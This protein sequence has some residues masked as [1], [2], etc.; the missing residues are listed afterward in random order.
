[1]ADELTGRI[2]I[3]IRVVPIICAIIG[4]S[5]F[6]FGFF[7]LFISVRTL[8]ERCDESANNHWGHQSSEDCELAGGFF[9][10]SFPILLIGII[11]LIVAYIMWNSNNWRTLI[12][13][14]V[15]LI[16]VFLFL[17]LITNSGIVSLA[18][19]IIIGLIF[20][21]KRVWLDPDRKNED[22]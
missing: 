3:L 1:M 7:F 6:S 18:I 5:N 17:I 10:I 21:L 4:F 13:E 12:K 8:W 22:K 11:F 15:F 19:I 2:G 14:M 9:Y 16:I 20:L